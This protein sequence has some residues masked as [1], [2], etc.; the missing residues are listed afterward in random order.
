LPKPGAAANSTSKQNGVFDFG[1]MEWFQNS[2]GQFAVFTQQRFAAIPTVT[3]EEMLD[4]NDPMPLWQS[5]TTR[6]AG[7]LNFRP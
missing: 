4:G 6:E 7:G 2:D 5:T 1:R 3:G